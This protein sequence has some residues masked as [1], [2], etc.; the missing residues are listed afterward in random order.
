MAFLLG[1]FSITSEKRIH[2]I[3]IGGKG[4]NGIAKICIKK[5]CTVTGSDINENEETRS[6]S[7]LGGKVYKG[8]SRE[9]IHLGT[10]LVVRSSIMADDCPEI[11]RANELNIPIVKRSEFLGLLMSPYKKISIAGSHGKSTTTA[12]M[13]LALE[14]AGQDPTV[15]A[16]AK[17]KELN[18]YERLGSGNFFVVESCE[19]DR[20]FHDLIGD[21][22]I[23]TSVE[24]SHME[25]F[26]DEGKMLQAF[27]EFIS[28]FNKEAVIFVNGDNELAREMSKL[29]QCK[30][31][32]YGT[33]NDN[34]YIIKNIQGTKNSTKFSVQRRGGA[35]IS[36]FVICVPGLYNVLNFTAI[37]SFFDKFKLPIDAVKKLGEIFTGVARRF[38]I[39]EAPNGIVFIDDFAHHPTQVKNLFDSI[40]Q[41]YPEHSVCAVFQ[42]RQHH[43]IKTFLAEYGEA[44]M[45][46]DEVIVTDIVPALGDTEA[47]KQSIS[48]KGVIDSIRK[49]SVPKKVVHIDNFEDIVEYVKKYKNTKTVIVTIGAGNVYRIR[50]MYLNETKH[51]TQGLQ[52]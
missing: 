35:D 18:G 13:G 14:Y 23:I 40:K 32:T 2:F 26:G 46:A 16:G 11:E 20:S 37:I 19:Y 17:I 48:A 50:D 21:I 15:I 52:K 5:G 47:D 24:K 12:L 9:N 45:Y 34:D 39:K 41:F 25:Y 27:R 36:D 43:L 51:E 6:I 1:N 3:G 33:K 28:K 38:E 31:I 4:L 44:F 7:A 42:P 22:G 29:A 49:R 30:I 10:D 8:H